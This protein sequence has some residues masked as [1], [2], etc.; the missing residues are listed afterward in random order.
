MIKISQANT[1]KTAKL[2]IINHT[3]IFD[4][5]ISIYNKALSFYID[6]CNKEWNSIE[7]LSSHKQ[8]AYIESIT[9]KTKTHPT[10][11]YDF[12][13]DFYKFPA[14]LRRAAIMEAVGI[15][16]SHKSRYI[17]WLEKKTVKNLHKK[18]FYEKPPKLNYK[19]KSF[20]VF[21][22]KEM[23]NKV[24]DGTATIKIFYKH[25]WV[26]LDIKYSVRN[27]M[28]GQ[29]YRFFDY[30]ELNPML[31]R[32]GHKYFLHIPYQSSTVFVKKPLSKRIVVG[33]DLGLNK[34]AVCSAVTSDGTVIGRLFIDQPIEKDRLNREIGRLAKAARKTGIYGSKPNYRR[35]INNLQK[36]I[37]QNTADRIVEFAARH[38]AYVISFEY[39]GR[40]KLPR[41]TWGAKRLRAKLQHWAKMRI[42]KTVIE[43]AH[44][45]GIR[46][47]RVLARGTSMY[48]YDSSGPVWRF[49][50][51]EIATFRNG[52][53]Y[54]ADLSASY[55]IASRYFIREFL[56]PLSETVRLQYQAKVPDTAGRTTQT[57]ASLIKL[58]EVAGTA[59]NTSE[60]CIQ[61]KEAPSIASA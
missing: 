29:Y 7:D 59:G 13:K 46:Y 43:K 38:N 57:L 6:V 56:K 20:P 44:S 5:T 25:D 45:I 14:Y 9:H 33:V 39:L 42:Q 52:K 12:D 53:I 27:L 48:A 49:G 21:Y 47:S 55:N 40:M 31:V 61:V 23:F 36:Y 51:H 41:N 26:W 32:K 3:G 4:D 50:N 15:I 22:K 10:V 19:P 30:K 1:V 24:A 18:K 35:R 2:K 8:L 16:K 54:H 34:S 60:A 17:T 28:T 37:V 58:H 11:R